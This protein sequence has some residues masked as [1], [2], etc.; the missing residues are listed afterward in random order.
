M[1]IMLTR[2]AYSSISWVESFGS[3][4]L[5]AHFNGNSVTII[6]VKYSPTEAE[7]SE[8]AEEYHNDLRNAL[9]T[10]PAQNFLLVVG[11]L[12]AKKSR[13]RDTKRLYFHQTTNRN[14]NLL[15]ETI[16]GANLE[17]TN[18]RFCKKPGKL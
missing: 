17:A 18:H 4:L 1:G 14:G 10:I 7:T 8:A 15:K 5:I 13:D 12:N 6:V 2:R 11:G 16:L 9:E 3:R